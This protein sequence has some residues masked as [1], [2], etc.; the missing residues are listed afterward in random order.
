MSTYAGWPQNGPAF[1]LE[2]IRIWPMSTSS[3]MSALND[4][5]LSSEWL[6]FDR[7]VHMLTWACRITCILALN[8]LHLTDDM[9]SRV[10]TE[11][12]AF[13]HWI[14]CM[15]D[16]YMCSRESTEWLA[17]RLWMTCILLMSTHAH[18]S[19]LNGLHLSSEWLA[20]DRWVHMLM[21]AWCMTCIWG[22][23]N[24]HLAWAYWVTCIW[25]LNDLHG[26]WITATSSYGTT[27]VIKVAPA[28][29]TRPGYKFHSREL[30]FKFANVQVSVMRACQ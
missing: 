18:V 2:M 15:T 5:H 7:W 13:E 11:W 19:E 9:G 16:E 23:N 25:T 4:L 27:P 20:F 26:R 17:F 3:H 8:D 30:C 10:R 1:E 12:L 21:W 14:N 29:P 6:A 24:L 22:L 28:N